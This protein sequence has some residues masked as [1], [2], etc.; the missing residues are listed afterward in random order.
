MQ[1]KSDHPPA[2]IRACDLLKVM[3]CTA[4][5]GDDI[6]SEGQSKLIC[7]FL[8]F[9]WCL[10]SYR[11][12]RWGEGVECEAEQQLEHDINTPKGSRDRI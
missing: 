6:A 12:A 3:K 5:S 7:D 10:T 2:Q 11:P 4:R 9:S 8:S 1:G